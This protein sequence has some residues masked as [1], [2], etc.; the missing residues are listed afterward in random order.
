[1]ILPRLLALGALAAYVG[2]RLRKYLGSGS[3]VPQAH[4]TAQPIEDILEEDPVC[5]RFIPRQE[6]L[7][8]SRSGMIQYFCS[9]ECR[10][11]FLHKGEHET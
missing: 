4:N 5:H 8:V 9:E 11:K 3:R 6:A 10:Q 1:M 7:T 2:L